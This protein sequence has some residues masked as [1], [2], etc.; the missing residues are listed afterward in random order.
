MSATYFSILCTYGKPK[1][2]KSTYSHGKILQGVEEELLTAVARFESFAYSN[3]SIIHTKCKFPDLQKKVL[4][5]QVSYTVKPMLNPWH[6]GLCNHSTS[7]LWSTPKNNVR[8]KTLQ[9]TWRARGG[10]ASYCE[11]C[12]LAVY[13]IPRWEMAWWEHLV[14]LIK[15]SFRW[16]QFPGGEKW[17]KVFFTP[18]TVCTAHIQS[19]LTPAHPLERHK[20]FSCETT[21]FF[22]FLPR[23]TDNAHTRG[24]QMFSTDGW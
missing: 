9:K 2:K 14:W 13:G 10:L 24:W 23:Q 1:A 17:P 19:Y 4:L 12:S 18:Q 15:L 21:N 5:H 22:S 7:L 16:N 11:F 20:I 6:M 8:A 3:S